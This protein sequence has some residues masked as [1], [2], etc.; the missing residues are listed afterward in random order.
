LRLPANLAPAGAAPGATH[1]PPRNAIPDGLFPH[2]HLD[3]RRPQQPVLEKV[4]FLIDIK[5]V[6]ILFFTFR[7]R[8]IDGVMEMRIKL[9]LVL[10]RL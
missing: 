4:P 1:L 7:R 9:A 6:L 2:G 8:L 5:D 3:H 10:D